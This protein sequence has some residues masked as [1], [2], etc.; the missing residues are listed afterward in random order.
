MDK[1]LLYSA[2]KFDVVKRDGKIGIEIKKVT[3]GVLPYVI[4]DGI[5]SSVG[6]LHEYSL[7]RKGNFCDTVITGTLDPD[8]T[9]LLSC[10]IR[11]LEEEGG[12][13]QNDVDKWVFLGT[14]KLSKVSTEEI[15]VFGVDVSEL[16]QGNAKGDGSKKERL[17]SLRM[18]Q[19]NDAI[20]T[21]ESIFLA[22]YLRLFD[23][24]YQSNSN[25]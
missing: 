23:F 18:T 25:K 4:S 11:E 14:F 6:V 21:D 8:D 13:I 20:L 10:A 19:I 16:E 12:F 9:G 2:K 24:F 5:L 1:E 3:V 7:F 15:S 17:S 22:S